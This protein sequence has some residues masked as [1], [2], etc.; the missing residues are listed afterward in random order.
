M[1]T[2]LSYGAGGFGKDFGLNVVNTFLFF[3]YT[4]VVGVSAYTIGLIFLVAR[5]WDMFAD[6]LFAYMVSKTKSRWGKY[7]PWI[8]VGTT[9]NCLSIIGLFSAH[10]FEG[11]AQI[12]F[13]SLTYILW[14]T[15]YTLADAPFW[16]LMPTITLDKKE[17]ERLMPYPRVCASLASYLASGTGIYAVHLLGKGNDGLGY[18][19]FAVISAV[20]C[21][22]SAIITCRWTQQRF[23]ESDAETESFNLK[24]AINLICRNDQLL[25]LLAIALFFNLASNMTA[26]LNIYYFSYV[27]GNGELFST[28]MLFAGISGLCSL[29]FFSKSVELV[30]RRT[31]FALSLLFPFF[32]AMVLYIALKIPAH[33]E[34]L[35]SVAG[36]ASGLSSALYW[37]IILIM[38][39]DTVDYGDM[40]LNL[41]SE[42]M[43]YSIHTL[44]IK[45]S[46]AVTGLLIGAALS[47]IHYIPKGI[48]M[49]ETIDNLQAIYMAPS[50]LCIVSLLI[51]FKFYK[52]NGSRLEYIQ[53]EL[54]KKFD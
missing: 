52:L 44:I 3:Y 49:P 17:R 48:Q 13:I 26:G 30:G 53:G 38:V 33:A 5:V 15:S 25:W 43:S 6:M 20:L 27:L 45:I 39:G 47:A 7:K 14:G 4:D 50:L 9:V 37:L 22:S 31:I 1:S 41:R 35:I 19:W 8:M 23:Q 12:V 36:I 40:K 11:N 21:M 46:G 24:K 32:S 42:A 10:L 34:L 18:F 2:K 16:S 29:F 51:Y 54:S 28:F